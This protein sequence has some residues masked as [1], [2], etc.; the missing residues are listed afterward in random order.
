MSKLTSGKNSC[1]FWTLKQWSLKQ[2]QDIVPIFE[3]DNS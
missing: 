2:F 3:Q 1:Y